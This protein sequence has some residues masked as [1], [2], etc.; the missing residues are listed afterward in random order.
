LQLKNSIL[1]LI[2]VWN[3]TVNQNTSI[4]KVIFACEQVYKMKV[5]D[6]GIKEFC[7]NIG[8]PWCWVG[9]VYWA[10]ILQ[11]LSSLLFL[12]KLNILISAA[13]PFSSWPLIDSHLNMLHVLQWKYNNYKLHSSVIS[14]RHQYHNCHYRITP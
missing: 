14:S 13:H 3:I 11:P 1:F 12:V 2:R 10:D 6:V 5:L 9:M 8:K 4:Q 7:D